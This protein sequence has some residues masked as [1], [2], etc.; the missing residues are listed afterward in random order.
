MAPPPAT[1]CM[2]T[3]ERSPEGQVVPSQTAPGTWLPGCGPVSTFPPLSPETMAGW[4][5]V[6][7]ILELGKG[8]WQLFLKPG[9]RWREPE[10][11][12]PKV[13]GS[14]AWCESRI[15]YG[16]SL[17]LQARSETQKPSYSACESVQTPPQRMKSPQIKTLGSRHPN[18]ANLF[19][20]KRG[21][22]TL[23]LPGHAS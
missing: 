10:Q 22:R 4:R 1:R 5:L 19:E 20:C 2:Q 16:L 13:L 21:S 15:P 7:Q 11:P 3:L 6:A 23:S 8:F 17:P 12:G 9:R 18:P 14:V